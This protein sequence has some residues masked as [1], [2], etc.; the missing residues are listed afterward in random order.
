MAPQLQTIHAQTPIGIHMTQM[1]CDSA[2]PAG[3]IS[4]K[5]RTAADRHVAPSGAG[6]LKRTINYIL[7]GR[8]WSTVT[9]IEHPSNKKGSKSQ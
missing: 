6:P 9:G 8:T 5:S 1:N 3:G 7:T 2:A 4:S